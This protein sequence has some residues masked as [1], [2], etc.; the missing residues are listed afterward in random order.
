M[1]DRIKCGY[2]F[3]GKEWFDQP[4][5]LSLNG[6]VYPSN[7]SDYSNYTLIP[8]LI[9]AHV[10][11]ALPQALQE[12]I[13]PEEILTEAGCNAD[14]LISHG[15]TAVRDAGDLQE[16]GLQLSQQKCSALLIQSGG[17]ALRRPHLYGSFLGAGT[18]SNNWPEIIQA[19]QQ[20]GAKHLK[21]LVSGIMS[22]KKYKQVGDLQF[23][24]HE[25]NELVKTAQE[26]GLPVMAHAS[27]DP[28]VKM[29]VAAGVQSIE[30]GYLVEQSTLQQMA[31]K[32]ITW[33]PTIAAVANQL[34]EP[35]VYKFRPEQRQIIAR[36]VFGQ[37]ER[38]NWAAEMGVPLA[39]GT[40]SGSSGVQHGRDYFT[41]L[42]LY[43]KAGL[44]TRQI[45]T[46][47]TSGG[48]RLIADYTFDRWLAIPGNLQKDL[49]L[50]K[51]IIAS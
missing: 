40:D 35:Q 45:L 6:S 51:H 25:L 23:T 26:A 43:Q 27:S 3:D 16:I 47:A 5:V 8:G 34:K 30:H 24:Q 2:F 17:A 1:V 41:E 14:Q 22:F 33:V 38:L 28:A 4:E 37:M 18:N 7:L 36:L 29:A 39:V 48:A 46:A 32:Q 42:Q 21:V 15:I 12:N 19:C 10:H 44:T 31:E 11:L 20:K 9:D 50:L 49:K 13:Q